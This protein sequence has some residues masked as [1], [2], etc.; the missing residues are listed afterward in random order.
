M[1]QTKLLSLI[2]AFLIPIMPNAEEE[3]WDIDGLMYRISKEKKTAELIDVTIIYSGDLVI[4]ETVTVKFYGEEY[5]VISIGSNTF[6]NTP[7]LTSVTIPNSVTSIG[8][9]AFGNCSSLTSVTIPNS[10]ISIGDLAFVDCNS[11][12]SVTIPNSVTYLGSGAFSRCS[13]LTS[14]TIP[15]SVTSIGSTFN[16]CSSL[17]SVTIPN[18]VTSIG[19]ETFRDCI[20]LTSVTIPNSVTSIGS[21][22]F[23]GCSGLT[24]VTIP[25]G[26][27]SI[28][29]RIFQECS[30]LTS[31]TIGSGVTDIGIKSF[32]QC[33][34]L[35]DFYCM[36][37]DVPNTYPNAFQDTNIEYATLHVPK[38]S[39]DAYKSVYPWK[40]FKDIVEVEGTGINEIKA[41]SV[42]EP[43]DV[44]DVSGYM[45]L[46]QVTSL[47]G[48]PN[49]IYIV[50][51]Q[52]ILKK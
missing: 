48:L 20:A 13:N 38:G 51:G 50:N 37:E 3:E 7:S 21:G 16:G 32:S 17:T 30:G 9:Q 25:N 4:P 39:L 18:S 10:V 52:K 44:Y 19:A 2:L 29:E 36:A 34:V 41:L 27:T 42:S 31:I 6:Y 5:S 24:S 47:D 11:L 49:G 45:V 15:N 28:N 8:E 35:T 33:P 46:S 23:R 22:T 26:V 1:K 14:V 40:S 43:F 12:T